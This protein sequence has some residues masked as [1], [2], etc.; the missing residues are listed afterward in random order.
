MNYL[1]EFALNLTIQAQ[2]TVFR[3]QKKE[4]ADKIREFG[5]IME[6]LGK[7]EESDF[8]NETVDEV[9]VRA[10]DCFFHL[11]GHYLGIKPGIAGRT[12]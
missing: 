4:F 7:Y 5:L 1:D 12:A 6:E 3:E 11:T 9:R 8:L 2:P 10:E